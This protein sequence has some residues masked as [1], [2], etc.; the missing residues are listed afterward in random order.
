MRC[1]GWCDK[2]VTSRQAE[3]TWRTA[4]PWGTSFGM[5]AR[6][7]EV[8][9]RRCGT[10]TTG[11]IRGSISR[12]TWCTADAP[13]DSGAPEAWEITSAAGAGSPSSQE[14][15]APPKIAGAAL[16][17]WPSIRVAT[18]S[19]QSRSRGCPGRAIPHPRASPATMAAAEEPSPRDWAIRLCARSINPHLGS[20]WS[21]SARARRIVAMTRWDSSR[22]MVCSPSPV[23]SI[24]TPR[25]SRTDTDTSSHRSRHSPRQS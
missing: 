13:S 14:S 15:C 4:S 3:S 12:S 6:A 8:G 7:A 18:P 19:A 22:A 11:W 9:T 20:G 17:G 10:K 16:S 25:P 5:T 23:T 21:R 1:S 2:D 24:S